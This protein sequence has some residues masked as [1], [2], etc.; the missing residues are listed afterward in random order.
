[1]VLVA[2]TSPRPNQ[3]VNGSITID[4]SVV[5]KLDSSAFCGA[6]GPTIITDVALDG[7]PIFQMPLP[8]QPWCPPPPAPWPQAVPMAIDTGPLP[9]GPHTITLTAHDACA[10]GADPREHINSDTI[11]FY[12]D[13][14]LPTINV[15][16]QDI[17]PETPGIQVYACTDVTYSADD[18]LANGYSSGLV[19]PF[20]GSI[21]VPLGEDPL[22]IIV[23]DRAGNVQNASVNAIAKADLDMDGD[24][25]ADDM[26]LFDKCHTGPNVPYDPEHLPVGCSLVPDGDGIIPADFDRDHDV[27]QVDFAVFQ[28]R[29]SGSGVFPT[30]S[31][32]D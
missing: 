21:A 6:C 7:T 8:P 12:V 18:P 28:R 29:F 2:V 22:E 30:G 15:T 27:D 10:P 13:K 3:P 25:D 11:T 16:S 9:D 23:A 20:H 1:L 5:H 26:D 14:T 4:G 32:T 17:D 19:D 24:V 31:C